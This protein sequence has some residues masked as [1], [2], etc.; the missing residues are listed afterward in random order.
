M[1]Q[2]FQWFQQ[3]P[4]LG[5]NKEKGFGNCTVVVKMVDCVGCSSL[6]L[7]L[8]LLVFVAILLPDEASF[9]ETYVVVV[10]RVSVHVWLDFSMVVID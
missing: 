2:L 1:F 4:K 7:A 8:L 9:G 6:T 10:T 3:G 5:Y